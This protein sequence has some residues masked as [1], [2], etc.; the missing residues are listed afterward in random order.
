MRGVSLYIALMVMGI[1]LA[2]ALGISTILFSQMR[3]MEGMGD[4]VL[5]F[6]ASNTGIERELYEDNPTGTSYSG[7][8]DLNQNGVQDGDD[9]VYNVTVIAA[10]GNGCPAEVNYCIKST[11]IYKEIRRAIRITR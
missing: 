8:L 3:V 11:G 9:S 4:S 7:Y 2:L 10:G 5:A 6:Y 1:L